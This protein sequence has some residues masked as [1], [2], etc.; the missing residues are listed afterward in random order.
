MKKNLFWVFDLL[1][2][3]YAIITYDRI[4]ILIALIQFILGFHELY[5]YLYK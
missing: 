2:L 3:T 5:K 1:V 4:L